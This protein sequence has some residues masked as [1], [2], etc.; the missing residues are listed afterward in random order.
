M[1]GLVVLAGTVLFVFS[2]ANLVDA[3][4]IGGG[5]FTSF[6]LRRSNY[7]RPAPGE[8]RALLNAMLKRRAQ[9]KSK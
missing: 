1:V 3:A 2:G 7:R 6:F 8:D 4:M 9:P 5:V